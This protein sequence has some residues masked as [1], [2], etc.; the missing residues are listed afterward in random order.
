MTK[1][2]D[3]ESKDKYEV[4]HIYQQPYP[5]VGQDPETPHIAVLK[6]ANGYTLTY[7]VEGTLLS[8]LNPGNKILFDHEITHLGTTT[9]TNLSTGKGLY[10]GVF[11]RNLST[12][13]VKEGPLPSF[14]A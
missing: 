4:T 6:N 5:P 8:D 1:T 3:D 10:L 2:K 13:E 7:L 14:P 11:A 9:A 12:E